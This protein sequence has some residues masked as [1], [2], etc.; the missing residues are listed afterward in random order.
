VF[1][2]PAKNRRHLR[3]MLDTNL[4]TETEVEERGEAE[5]EEESRKR[6]KS[7][8]L[9]ANVSFQDYVQ[10]SR[11]LFEFVETED[12]TL[13]NVQSQGTLVGYLDIA[14]PRLWILHSIGAATDMND[15]VRNMT[16]RDGSMID[17][18]WLPS[19][20]LE[21]IGSFGKTGA[22][23]NLRY[24][25]RFPELGTE[26]DVEDMTMRFWGSAALELIEQL[27]KNKRIE[28]GLSLS[29]IGLIHEVEKGYVKE[30]ISSNGRI[31]AIRGDSIDSHFSVVSKVQAYYQD[32]LDL[33]ES[34]YRF[35]YEKLPHGVAF[36]G[37]ALT[38]LFE[39]RITNLKAFAEGMFS[40]TQPFRLWGVVKTLESDRVK[41]KAVDLHSNGRVD[42]EIE[43]TQMRIYLQAGSC[44]NVVTRLFTNLQ[45]AFDARSRLIGHDQPVI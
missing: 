19:N 30:Q 39:R 24:K 44:A 21:R 26:T 43:P 18:P 25:N 13:W 33:L 11:D 31:M 9:E 7:Q 36:S 34:E 35:S 3:E 10:T 23:F 4:V 17:L 15:K 40:T 41:I 1:T 12:S 8:L 29:G 5:E 20:S 27:K 6:T 14:N 22:G 38:I 16:E 45:S 42:F 37:D 32:L 28:G 2:V